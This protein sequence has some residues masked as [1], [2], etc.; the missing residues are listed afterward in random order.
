MANGNTAETTETE[1]KP[2]K[3]A[4]ADPG[5]TASEAEAG[6][7]FSKY[8]AASKEVDGHEKAAEVAREARNTITKEIFEKCGKGPFDV[9]GRML[10]LVVREDEESGKRTY[11]FRGDTEKNIVSIKLPK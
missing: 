3:K 6:K 2:K 11:F 5:M 10:T 7:L 8:L 4:V 1:K 9:A